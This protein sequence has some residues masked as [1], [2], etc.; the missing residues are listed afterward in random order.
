MERQR[1]ESGAGEITQLLNLWERGD[2][3]ALEAL[4]P[5]VYDQLREIAQACLRRERPDGMLQPTAMVNEVFTG[6]LEIRRVALNDRSHFFAFAARLTRRILVDYARKSNAEKRG[7]GWQR[8]PLDTELAWAG[9]DGSGGLDL[10]RALDELSQMDP[11]K[12]RIVELC[13][14]LGCTVE[15][16]AGLLNLS[17]RTVERNLRF[18]LVFLRQRLAAPPGAERIAGEQND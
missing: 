13:Y 4:V 7:A 3:G 1:G 8:I 18:S 16:I 6:L 2:P 17:K 11:Q 10:S 5:L 14:F 12:T 9:D 15:E